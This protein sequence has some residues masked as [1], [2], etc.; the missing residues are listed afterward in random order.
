MAEIIWQK[1]VKHYRVK[2][3]FYAV[4]RGIKYLQWRRACARKGIDWRQFSREQSSCT[5]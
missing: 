1:F 4:Y 5:K 3:F 2:G